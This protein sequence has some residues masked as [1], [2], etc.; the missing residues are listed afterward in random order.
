MNRIL[1]IG[2]KTFCIG[3]PVTLLTNSH[4]AFV[5]TFSSCW[6]EALS[7]AF[8]L[9]VRQPH[10][11]GTDTYPLLYNPIRFVEWT[12][13]MPILTRRSHVQVHCQEVFAR[14]SKN[15]TKVTSASDT[16]FPRHTSTS[17]H[18]WLRK[19]GGFGFWFLCTIVTLRGLLANTGFFLSTGNKIPFHLQHHLISF[20]S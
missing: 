3:F 9:V 8:Y 17:C 10:D 11:A 6:E 4:S 19:C 12:S 18:G 16:S 1:R 20:G 13:G 7:V 14:L 2:P 5:F 15:H